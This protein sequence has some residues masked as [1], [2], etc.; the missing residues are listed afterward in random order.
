ML[1]VRVPSRQGRA[2]MRARTCGA[3]V[4]LAR[5]LKVAHSDLTALA[6]RGVCA[7]LGAQHAPGLGQLLHPQL[8]RRLSR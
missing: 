4:A 3:L 7:V 8:L 2:L 1:R 5:R 6:L